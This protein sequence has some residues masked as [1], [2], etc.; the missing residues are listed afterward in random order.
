M[1]AVLI[2]NHFTLSYLCRTI[3]VKRSQQQSEEQARGEDGGVDRNKVIIG[4]ALCLIASMAWGAMF[5]VAGSALK[6]VDAFYFTLIRYVSV[7][8]LLVLLLL[9]KEGRKAFRFEGKGKL[10]L[11]YGT[12]AFAVYN[13]FIFW[14]QEL[15]GE[16]GIIVASL[17]EAMMPMIS[18]GLVW[19]MK[20][21]APPRYAILSM[22]VAFIGAIFVITKGNWAFFLSL[23][24]AFLPLLFLFIAVVGWV[25]YTMGG[26]QFGDWSILRYST[27][28]CVLGTFVS[29]IIVGI[30]SMLGLLDVPTLHTV[31]TI[32]YEMGYMILIAGLAALLSWNA[33][34]KRLGAVNG[35]LFINFVPITTLVIMAIQ[36]YTI[37]LFEYYGTFL[38]ILALIYNNVYQRKSTVRIQAAQS[39]RHP[40]TALDQPKVRA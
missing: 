10:L 7:S 16:P 25:V 3:K 26:S 18:I 19:A 13:I 40:I 1:I 34:I 29:F 33:G 22:I 31:W 28:T 20:R 5:P 30:G 17:M 27:L 14:G 24:G 4:S 11:F 9:F 39:S 23:Q 32:K 12:M 37:S 36:G 21:K 8:V 35:I 38:V 15:M 6:H 2:F